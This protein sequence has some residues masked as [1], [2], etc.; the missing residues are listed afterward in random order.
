LHVIDLALRMDGYG[1]PHCLPAVLSAMPHTQTAESA[2]HTARL[3]CESEPV[4]RNPCTR[5]VRPVT[6]TITKMP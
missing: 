3:R 4:A 6:P 1:P 2:I 5:I